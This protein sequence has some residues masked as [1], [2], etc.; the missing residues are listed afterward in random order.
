M[1]VPF[2][3][4]VFRK[5][6]EPIDPRS[7]YFNA[8]EGKANDYVYGVQWNRTKGK[9]LLLKH[10]TLN[11]FDLITPQYINSANHEEIR[12]WAVEANFI[13]IQIWGIAGVRARAFKPANNEGVA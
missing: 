7:M 1:G 6:A 8:L 13:D 11:A 4:K 10:V 5:F 12:Q 9:E 2:F 3:N